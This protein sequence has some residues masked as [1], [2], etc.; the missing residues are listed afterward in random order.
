[1]LPSLVRRGAP[2]ALAG[3]L[4]ALLPLALAGTPAHASAICT[5]EKP[6]LLGLTC[7]DE[8][9]PNTVSASA[10]QTA[11]GQVTVSAAYKYSDA[12]KDPVG[13]QC[14]AKGTAAWVPCVVGNLAAGDYDFLIRA[15]DT[16]DLALV[17][18]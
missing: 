18:K 15:V 17:T 10:K 5:S 13:F 4:A 9:P 16:A 7:D 1:M 3:V 2:L 14:Q 11:P 6:G 12:D 8:L